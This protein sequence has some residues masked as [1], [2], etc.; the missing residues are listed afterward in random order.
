MCKR[1]RLCAV[2]ITSVLIIIY[3][4]LPVGWMIRTSLLDKSEL[5]KSPARFLIKEISI[6]NYKQMLGVGEANI[7]TSRNFKTAFFNSVKEALLSTLLIIVIAVLA[8]YVF[9]RV[10]TRITQILFVLLLVTMVLPAYSVMLPLYR[11]M[12]GLN[13]LDTVTGVVLIYVSAFMPLAIWIM[14]SFFES[15]PTGIEESAWIDGSSRIKAMLLILPLAM[16]GIIAAAIISFLSVWSQYAIPLVFASSDAQ[17]LTVFLTTLSG[18]S[19]VNFGLI[20]A[21]GMF[22]ILPPVIIVIFLNR[23][24]VSGLTKGAVK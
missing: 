16:P 10:K 5:L 21:G 14:R 13:L 1:K 19:S 9:A 2:I 15:V 4:I 11:I 23:F 8:G 24:L 3:S 12:I 20:S 22:T 17:P 7:L 6:D 18:K